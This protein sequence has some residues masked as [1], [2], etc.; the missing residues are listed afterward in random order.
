MNQ[1]PAAGT[2]V[3]TALPGVAKNIRPITSKIAARGWR[4]RSAQLRSRGQ[5][6]I[7]SR[8]LRDATTRLC[9]SRGSEGEG[10][11]VPVHQPPDHEDDKDQPEEAAD[12]DW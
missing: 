2:V 12:P 11:D 6:T 4:S 1:A 10:P 9:V 8:R 5:S 7:C 3:E